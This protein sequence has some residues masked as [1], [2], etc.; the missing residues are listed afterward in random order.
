MKRIF[1]STKLLLLSVNFFLLLYS[2]YSYSCSM[3]FW[4]NNKI[5]KVVARSMDLYISD[6]PQLVVNP[7]GIARDGDAGENSLKWT[8]KYGSVVVTAFNSDA[9]SDGMNEEGLSVHLLYLDNTQYGKRD[10]KI[11]AVTN[12][13]WSQYFLDNFKSVNEAVAASKN[14]QI[15]SKSVNGREWPIHLAMQDASGDSAIIEFI[16][17][18]M[19]IYHGSQYTVMTNEPAYHIQLENLKNYQTF[20]GKLSLP[21]GADPLSRFVRASYF[22]KTLPNPMM[23]VEAIADVLSVLRTVAVPF[24]AVDISGS[25][26]VDGWPTRWMTVAD[27]TNKVYYF[28]STTTPNIVWLDFSYLDFK[29]GARQL[30]IDPTNLKLVGEISNNM[31]QKG[32]PK[33]K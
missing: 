27:L 1:I 26:T 15:V 7:R 18:K 30:T 25:G 6:A 23:R 24:G 31:I 22:L 33:I 28:N 21:G 16:D 17:G 2:G 5:A 8:S 14:F 4:N 32:A 19:D 10:P 11:A 29:E 13:L 12:V 9:A 3:V 20:G